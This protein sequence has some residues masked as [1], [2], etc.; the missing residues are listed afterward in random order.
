LAASLRSAK[1]PSDWLARQ[2]QCLGIDPRNLR[3]DGRQ[4]K[5]YELADFNEAVARLPEDSDLPGNF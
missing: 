1:S 5:G 4:A 2:L 3:L